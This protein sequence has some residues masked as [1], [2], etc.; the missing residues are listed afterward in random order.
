[1]PGATAEMEVNCI[2]G[3]SALTAAI[4][5]KKIKKKKSKKSLSDAPMAL[6]DEL[7]A[8]PAPIS[9]ADDVSV[10]PEWKVVNSAGGRFNATPI[11]YSHDA[12]Y[13]EFMSNQFSYHPN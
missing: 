8:P 7:P 12:E 2:N 9:E 13:V 5:T 11:L 4:K 3:S 1:M 10:D 6:L